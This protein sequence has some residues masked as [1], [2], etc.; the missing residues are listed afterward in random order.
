MRVIRI[1]EVDIVPIETATPNPGWTGG[2]V[3]RTRPP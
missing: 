1:A 2:D 3:Q